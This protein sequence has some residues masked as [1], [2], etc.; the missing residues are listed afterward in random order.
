[1]YPTNSGR[2]ATLDLDRQLIH[3]AEKQFGLF[4]SSQAIRCGV[5]EP[6]LNRRAETKT[7]VRVHQGVYRLGGFETFP[8]QQYL[9]AC[10]AVPGSILSGIAAARIHGLP[11][12][13]L[14]APIVR[15]MVVIDAAC[16]STKEFL[17]RRT[18][19]LP[20]SRPWKG[21]QIATVSETIISLAEYL[22]RNDLARCIDHAVAERKIDVPR[23]IEIVETRGAPAVRGRAKLRDELAK[24]TTNTVVY[25]SKKEAIVASWLRSAH[26]PPFLTNYPVVVSDTKSVEVDVVWPEYVVALEISPFFTHGSEQRQRRDMERRRELVNAGFRVVE[27]TDEHLVNQKSFAPIIET[28]SNLLRS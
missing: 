4:T 7:I 6:A 1:M 25:R 21:G 24:R 2:T 11:V 27:A 8:E 13:P 15:P 3:C 22:G 5:S 10:L 26:L 9:A 14:W 28:L 20:K 23:I 19:Y 16:R 17:V 12:G 18:K